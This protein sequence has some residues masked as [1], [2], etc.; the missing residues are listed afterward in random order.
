MLD[1][2]LAAAWGLCSVPGLLAGYAGF[3]AW[4]GGRRNAREACAHCG[5]PQYAR[6]DYHAPALVQGRLVC[7]PCAERSRRRL[8]VALVG[9][10]A[11]GATAVL[12]VGTAAVM[13]TGG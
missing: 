7:A 1:W 4:R 6:P 8:R 13:G 3:F 12:A 2:G 9:A 11:L 5:G 10:G